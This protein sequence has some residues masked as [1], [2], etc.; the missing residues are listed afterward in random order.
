M[1]NQSFSAQR[2]PAKISLL[3][4][5]KREQKGNVSLSNGIMIVDQNRQHT[6]VATLSAPFYFYV[7][8]FNL[9]RMRNGSNKNNPKWNKEKKYTYSFSCA[10]NFSQL[11][12]TITTGPQAKQGAY[13]SHMSIFPICDVGVFLLHTAQCS[14]GCLLTTSIVVVDV[15]AAA[16]VAANSVLFSPFGSVSPF[17]YSVVHINKT[18][19]PSCACVTNIVDPSRQH[20]HHHPSPLS[21]ST[22]THFIRALLLI[23]CVRIYS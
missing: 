8:Q 9:F 11:Y 10:S 5:H 19:K 14:V 7:Y 18:Y 21:S 4:N 2:F 12:S 16:A 6:V 13:N 15:V 3:E 17:G 22:A 23:F 1:S 20:R